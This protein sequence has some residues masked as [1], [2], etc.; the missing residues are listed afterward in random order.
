MT[1][2]LEGSASGY[3]PWQRMDPDAPVIIYL[4]AFGLS[5][6]N[7]NAEGVYQL[8]A[9]GCARQRATLG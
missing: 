2:R 6:A 7:R 9:Q 8:T 5:D 1:I 4:T 3:H